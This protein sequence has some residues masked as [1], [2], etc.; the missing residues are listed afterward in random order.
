M[1]VSA[2]DHQTAFDEGEV[3]IQPAV[4]VTDADNNPVAGVAVTFA[5]AS[6]GGSVIGGSQATNAAG[7]ATV[8]AWMLGSMPG[9]NTLTATAVGAVMDGNPITFYA[10][11]QGDFWTAGTPMPT[12]RLGA[13]VGVINGVLYAV[14]GRQDGSLPVATVEAYDPLTNAW[15]TKASMP[16]PRFFMAIAVADGRLYAVGGFNQAGQEVGTVEVYDPVTDTW[17]AKSSMPTPRAHLGG[18]SYQRRALR[19]RWTDQHDIRYAGSL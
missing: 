15:T 3:P 19:G 18:R 12:S 16:A 6:G 13:G 17:M 14:G 7:I 10:T 9:L 4:L 8:G 2:G 5:V 11:A 1:T